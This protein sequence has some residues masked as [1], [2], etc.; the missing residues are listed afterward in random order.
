LKLIIQSKESPA[1]AELLI[2][3]FEAELVKH[4]VAWS[5]SGQIVGGREVILSKGKFSQTDTTQ[6]GIATSYVDLT[7]GEPGKE[8][9]WGITGITEVAVSFK[10]MFCVFLLSGGLIPWRNSI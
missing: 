7:L 9:S 2:R 4:M 8:Q 10:L 3:G 6:E 5:P 1:L